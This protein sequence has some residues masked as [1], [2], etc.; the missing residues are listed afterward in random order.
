MSQCRYIDKKHVLCL[1]EADCIL[2]RIICLQ[3]VKNFM[4]SVVFDII[5][6]KFK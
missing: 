3:K 4:N 1:S 5:K 6:E 2:I